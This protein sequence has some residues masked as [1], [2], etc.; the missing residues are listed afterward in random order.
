M[1]HQN[2][3]SLDEV[4]QLLLNARLRDELEPFL[5]EATDMLSTQQVPLEIENDFLASMLA[6]ERAPALP[7]SRWFSPELI[8]PNPDTLAA[9]AL[10]RLLWDTI[11]KLYGERI[12]LEFTDHLSDRE[13][14]CMI[15][16]DI[17][18]SYEKKID[19]PR[20]FLHWHCLDETET[21]KWLAYYATNEERR[22]WL[23]ENDGALPDRKPLPFARKM[24]CRPAGM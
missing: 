9:D 10:T 15:V 14:Y 8:L 13:L 22:T 11:Y 12:V 24:P 3:P 1:S 6:W 4:E 21:E 17:L 16:R 2:P 19:E 20:N 7:I 5:D 23:L 18:P